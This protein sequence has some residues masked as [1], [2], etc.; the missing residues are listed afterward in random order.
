MPTRSSIFIKFA[1]LL[2]IAGLLAILFVPKTTNHS[3]TTISKQLPSLSVLSPEKYVFHGQGNHKETRVPFCLRG[4]TIEVK[5]II[6]GKSVRCSVDTGSAE[7]LWN[8]RLQL[9]DQRSGFQS[10]ASDAGGHSVSLQE[11]VLDSVQIGT[12]ELKHIRSYAITS[13]NPQ[14]NPEISLGNS[15]FAHTVL[16][17]DYARHELVIQPPFSYNVMARISDPSNVLSFQWISADPRNMLGAPC[18][19]AKVMG[20][21][22][23]MI[24]DTGWVCDPIDLSRSFYNRLVPRLEANHVKRHKAVARFLWGNSDIIIIDRL[25]SS[26][27]GITLTSPAGTIEALNPGAQAVLGYGFLRILRTTIDYPDRK[28]WFEPVQARPVKTLSH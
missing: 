13:D 21:P 2:A 8:A 11:A 28:I 12:L 4:G 23:N 5:A 22:V 20:L 26:F 1:V 10:S 27:A 16:T 3:K 14:S 6:N 24:I 25:S 19:H 7:I 17:I 15:V 9:T 18:V